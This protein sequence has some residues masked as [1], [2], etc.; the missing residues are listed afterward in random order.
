[1]DKP[2]EATL[3]RTVR[4]RLSPVKIAIRML[5]NELD[6]SGEGRVTFERNLAEDLLVSLELFVEDLESDVGVTKP[7][8]NGAL[9]ERRQTSL[10]PEKPVTRLN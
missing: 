9:G 8:T 3:T 10:T 2:Q 6:M 4:R 5:Q 1:M 7:A